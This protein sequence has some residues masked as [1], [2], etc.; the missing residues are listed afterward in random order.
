M[1]DPT[2]PASLEAFLS[3]DSNDTS[4]LISY[5][6]DNPTRTLKKSADINLLI[7]NIFK[8]HLARSWDNLDSMHTQSDIIV[9]QEMVFNLKKKPE[10]YDNHPETYWSLGT[11]FTNKKGIHT[12]T[13]I[14]SDVHVLET[15][16]LTSPDLEPITGTPKSSMYQ[17]YAIDQSEDTLLIANMHA[18]NFTRIAKFQRQIDSLCEAIRGHE[19]PMIV[20][21]D[22][23]TH[24]PARTSYLVMR[25]NE[26]DLKLS[27]PEHDTRL[28]PYTHVFYRNVEVK[29]H[30]MIGGKRGSD[31]KPFVFSFQLS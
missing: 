25:M 29:N 11:S 24:F 22:F 6:N 9:L 14:G 13:A 1:T 16:F 27:L 10:F 21:G 20:T 8:G 30:Q 19:G 31:H 28:F 17:R 26:L 5:R 3:R 7:W 2:T 23:N 18:I 4:Q 12:G 15:A